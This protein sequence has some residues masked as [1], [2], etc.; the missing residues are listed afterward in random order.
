MKAGFPEAWS[1][2]LGLVRLTFE[3]DGRPDQL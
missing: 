2:G 3:S 1:T